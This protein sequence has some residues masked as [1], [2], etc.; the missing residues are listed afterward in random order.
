MEEST[1]QIIALVIAVLSNVFAAMAAGL[2]YRQSRHQEKMAEF[3]I[4]QSLRDRFDSKDMRDALHHLTTYRR[5]KGRRF[6][7]TWRADFLADVSSAVEIDVHRRLIK[8]FGTTLAVACQEKAISADLAAKVISGY[9][10]KVHNEIVLPMHA[11]LY[12]GD[13]RTSRDHILDCIFEQKLR[14]KT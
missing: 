10:I 9:F 14:K 6:A 2:I 7:Q 12:S 11:E 4:F 8:S 3:T 13:R 1:V 5:Q